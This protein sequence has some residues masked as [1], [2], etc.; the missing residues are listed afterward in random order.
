MWDVLAGTPLWAT[1][2]HRTLPVFAS[3]Q[4]TSQ[5][6]TSAGGLKRSPPKYSPFLATSGLPSLTT[7]VRKTLSP[8]RMGDDQP[9]P[10][11][12]VFQATFLVVLQV[13]GRLAPSPTP[14][15][16]LPRNCG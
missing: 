6:W 14:A 11:M 1:R 16:C 7:E 2:S 9:L 8:Q 5:R 10:G 15:A 4:K 13:S 3:R 12:G